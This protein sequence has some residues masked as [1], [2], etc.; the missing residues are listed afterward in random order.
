M[1]RKTAALSAVLLVIGC[2][3]L[4]YLGTPLL[5][6]KKMS[7]QVENENAFETTD[8]SGRSFSLSKLSSKPV[9]V[10]FW[11]TWC[12]PCV[13]EFPQM[14]KFVESFEGQIELVAVSADHS[15]EDVDG[16]IKRLGIQLPN[17]VHMIRD[18]KNQIAEQY[19]ATMLPTSVIL[20][21]DF[22]VT[23]RI[24]GEVDWAAHELKTFFNLLVNQDAL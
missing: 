17:N 2:V 7:Q 22:K 6:N 24:S 18:E 10:H 21:R 19:R 5:T 15:N 3:V 9:I 11:A 4:W 13:T 14:I 8:M 20:N 23:K 12:P 1:K 16:F